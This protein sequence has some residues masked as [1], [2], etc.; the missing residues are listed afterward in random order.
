MDWKIRRPKGRKVSVL[1][2]YGRRI[3]SP[4]EGVWFTVRVKPGKLIKI[5]KVSEEE[6]NDL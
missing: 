6:I 2:Q 5:Y 4:G 1:D 3:L